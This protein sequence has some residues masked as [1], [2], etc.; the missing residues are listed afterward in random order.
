LKEVNVM[1]TIL[2]LVNT[3]VELIGGVLPPLPL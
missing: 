3:V 1:G 2:D